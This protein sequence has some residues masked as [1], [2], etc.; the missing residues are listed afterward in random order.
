MKDLTERQREV[1]EF[2]ARYTQENGRPPAL[3]EIGA[4]FGM[5]STN[6]VNDHLIALERKGYITRDAM[7]ARGI[8]LLKK[9]GAS[10]PCLD[11]VLEKI[12]YLRRAYFR[13][14]S[15]VTITNEPMF[16]ADVR[17]ALEEVL[18]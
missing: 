11:D 14:G 5:Q 18:R 7:T 12:R 4:H 9:S 17:K 2:L 13:C 3:R 10:A 16:I 8:R 1:W 6:A 15:K